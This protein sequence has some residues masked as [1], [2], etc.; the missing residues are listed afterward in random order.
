MAD[1]PPVRN[2]VFS[3]DELSDWSHYHTHE[4]AGSF[5]SN[6]RMGEKKL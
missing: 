1:D 2:E 5:D 4:H 3:D 6:F